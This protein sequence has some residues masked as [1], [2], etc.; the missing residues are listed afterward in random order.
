MAQAAHQRS[1]NCAGNNN[2]NNSVFICEMMGTEL[3]R[4]LQF[5]V[6]VVKADQMLRIVKKTIG[7]KI[8][9]PYIT[10]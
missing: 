10:I 9:H 2:D 1:E 7:S 6:Q 3:T 4:K 5:S 8:Q